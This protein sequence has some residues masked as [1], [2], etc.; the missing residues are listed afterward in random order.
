VNAAQNWRRNLETRRKNW[1]I[2]RTGSNQLVRSRYLFILQAIHCTE[3]FVI[4]SIRVF[5]LILKVYGSGLISFAGHR[6]LSVVEI[7]NSEANYLDSF[8]SC[9]AYNVNLL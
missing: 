5:L 4:D 3:V 2:M 6:P 7:G 8:H 1:N 9:V